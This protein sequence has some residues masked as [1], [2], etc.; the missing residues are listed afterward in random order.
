MR[1]SGVR[2]PPPTTQRML[3]TSWSRRAGWVRIALDITGANQAPVS[4]SAA[5]AASAQT[6]SKSRSIWI[7]PPTHSTAM[8]GRSKAPT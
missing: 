7:M 3:L 8:P 5:M 6:G 4:L 2:S 1:A